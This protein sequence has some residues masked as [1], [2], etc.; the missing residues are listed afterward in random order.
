MRLPI[1]YHTPMNDPRT[2]ATGMILVN[3]P[4]KV[5]ADL[6]FGGI[7]RSGYRRELLGLGLKDKIKQKLN[8]IIDVDVRV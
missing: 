7:Q 8:T 3:H 5:A 6:P 1:T 4:T 2:N